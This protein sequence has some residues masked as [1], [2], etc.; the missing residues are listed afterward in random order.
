MA[1]TP[2]AAQTQ[3]LGRR[4]R[5]K[6]V[7]APSASSRQQL[8]RGSAPRSPARPPAAPG[9][10]PPGPP[11]TRGWRRRTCG[12]SRSAASRPQGTAAAQL[13][14]VRV[15]W[16]PLTAGPRITRGVRGRP[17]PRALQATASPRD[18]RVPTLPPAPAS[19]PLGQL[20]ALRG[21]R[22][23]ENGGGLRRPAS[24]GRALRLQT[25]PSPEPDAAVNSARR[26][27]TGVGSS[28]RGCRGVAGAPP[29]LR[30]RRMSTERGFQRAAA[31]IFEILLRAE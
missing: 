26:R 10:P 19:A 30:W 31:S 22:Q 7:A 18:R 12:E 3:Y 16:A 4:H 9:T 5:F 1:R 25:Q 17:R 21:R 23:Q 6:T 27:C 29:D 15:A 8:R 13:R 24:L 20:G 2:T 28:R 11:P 14:Q